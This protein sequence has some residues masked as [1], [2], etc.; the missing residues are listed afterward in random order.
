MSCKIGGTS[1]LGA[2]ALICSTHLVCASSAQAGCNCIGKCEDGDNVAD[3]QGCA[4]DLTECTS[5]TQT[6]CSSRK[7]PQA[8]KSVECSSSGQGC[9]VPP[10]GQSCKVTCVSGTTYDTTQLSLPDC[11]NYATGSCTESGVATVVFIP[12]PIVPTVTPWG[13]IALVSILLLGMIAKFARRR[14]PTGRA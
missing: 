1:V 11:I 10:Q 12:V 6:V 9:V 4:K 3:V 14:V 2:L 8:I 5:C 13:L 7:P